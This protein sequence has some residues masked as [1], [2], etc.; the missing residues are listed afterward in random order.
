VAFNGRFLSIHAATSGTKSLKLPV[1]SN[2]YDIFRNRCIAENTAEF[3]M[4]M[5]RGE[6][7]ICFIGSEEEYQRFLEAQ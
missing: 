4:D 3:T 2:V 6:T 7:N 5:L 1:K